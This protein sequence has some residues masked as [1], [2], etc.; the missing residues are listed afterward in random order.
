MSPPRPLH[1]RV[2]VDLVFALETWTRANPSRDEVTLPLD[3][4]LDDRNVYA[5]DVLFYADDRG[6]GRSEIVPPPMPDLAVEARSPA[7]WR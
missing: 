4:Q 5:P 3:V 2:L 7:T 1:Q 6:P